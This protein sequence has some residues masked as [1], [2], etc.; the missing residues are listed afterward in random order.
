[1][2]KIIFAI[3][4][5]CTFGA[6]ATNE[7]MATSREYVDAELTTMQPA[8]PATDTGVMTYDSTESTGIGQNRFTIHQAIIQHKKMPW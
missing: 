3:C 7:E 4:M 2:K 6:F 5:L 1:M 8:I